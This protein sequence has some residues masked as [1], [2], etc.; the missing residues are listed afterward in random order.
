MKKFF[1]L[2]VLCFM[3]C[4]NANAQLNVVAK[5]KGYT[6]LATSDA[7]QKTLSLNQDSGVYY[8]IDTKPYNG[9]SGFSIY[10]PLGNTKESALI[11]LKELLS[12]I[13]NTNENIIIKGYIAHKNFD[14]LI[15][16][17]LT[18]TRGT[19]LGQGYLDITHPYNESSY[20]WDKNDINKMIKALK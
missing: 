12:L 14:K 9:Y 2:L 1:F 16:I 10:I 3:V 4:V 7:N 20:G 11:S 19:I 5:T 13:Q 6:T 18:I 15:P 8:L 17:E